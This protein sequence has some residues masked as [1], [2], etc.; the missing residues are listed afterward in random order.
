MIPKI[1]QTRIIEWTAV[2]YEKGY[3]QYQI[4]DRGPFDGSAVWITQMALKDN[5]GARLSGLPSVNYFGS[6]E[7]AK[8]AVESLIQNRLEN[9]DAMEVTP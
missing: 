2:G 6:V 8:A 5:L 9:G 7:R 4:V 3:T 1:V